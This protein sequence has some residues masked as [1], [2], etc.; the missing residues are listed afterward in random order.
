M[1]FADF[2]IQA[3]NSGFVTTE[4]H[5]TIELQLHFIRASA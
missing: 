2:D 1:Q 3:P 4:D 5:G